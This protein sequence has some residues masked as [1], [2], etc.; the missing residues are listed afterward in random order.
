VP[1]YLKASPGKIRLSESFGAAPILSPIIS[2]AEA[3]KWIDNKGLK[4][5][6]VE[7]HNKT[8]VKRRLNVT[9]D[10]LPV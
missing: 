5:H 10:Q 2:G 7:P 9:R 6:D 8:I 3:V 1:L 4:G